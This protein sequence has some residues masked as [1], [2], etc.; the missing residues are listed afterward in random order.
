M[1]A[2]PRRIILLGPFSPPI[3]GQ[4]ELFEALEL[5]LNKKN[6]VTERINTAFSSFTRSRW[7]KRHAR[8]FL[9]LFLGALSLRLLFLRKSTIYLTVANSWPGF[10]RDL[11]FISASRIRNHRLVAHC[12]CGNYDEFLESNCQ[13]RQKLIRATLNRLDCLIILSESFRSQF[14]FLNPHSV[15]IRVVANGF[16]FPKTWHA[17]TSP[18]VRNT[19]LLSSHGPVHRKPL[20]IIF[21]SNLI[22]SKGYLQLLDAISLLRYQHQLE[23]T[24]RFYGDFL[25]TDKMSQYDGPIHARNDFLQ[26]VNDLSLKS[27]V[28]LNPPVSGIDKVSA[29]ADADLFVLPTFY[30]NEA[31]P[32]SVIEAMACRCVV[33][34]TNYRGIPELLDHGKAGILIDTPSPE[35]IVAPIIQLYN[36]ADLVRHYQEA[37]FDRYLERYQGKTYSENLYNLLLDKS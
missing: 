8:I 26:R 24:A 9:P 35:Q 12:H 29:L 27:I 4:S 17:F 20:R 32:L 31:Q 5:S 34:S 23:V 28:S 10:L 30:P 3:T 15:P 11:L 14:T 19:F 1:S 16:S 33:I 36:S 25:I 7:M 21:L 13:L 37:A 6:I 2:P 18:T 22:E